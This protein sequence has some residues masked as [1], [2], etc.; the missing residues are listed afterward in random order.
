MTIN[1]NV[2]IFE[3]AAREKLRFQSVKGDLT[4]E[5][6]FDLPLT[7][8]RTNAAS[9]DNV[10]R[11]IAR[12]LREQAEESF[13][14]SRPNPIKLLLTLR[15]EVVKAV[16]ARKQEE[17]AAKAAALAAR[18]RRRVLEEALANVELKKI[19]GMDEAA[20]RAEL[21]ALPK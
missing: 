10:A 9:L 5:Q 8:E 7:T 21:D 1:T 11:D 20:I 18:E 3:Q 2:N 14:D 4:T 15:L 13:V 12:M 16:I 17:N 6:L 19:E